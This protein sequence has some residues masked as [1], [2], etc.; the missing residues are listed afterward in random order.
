MVDYSNKCRVPLIVK[1]TFHFPYHSPT[2]VT[3]TMP[4]IFSFLRDILD[5]SRKILLLSD[6]HGY[7]LTGFDSSMTPRHHL[8]LPEVCA[9]AQYL[10]DVGLR[11]SLARQ[12]S[13]TYMD[14]VDRYRKACESHFER[15]TR[16]G[17]LTEYYREVFIVLFKRTTQ[18]WGSQIVSIVRMRICQAGTPLATIGPER[19][20]V[21]A[22]VNVISK[23]LTMLCL[24]SL[25]YA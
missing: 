19:L 10:I 18:A 1:Q 14:S 15:A 9:P 23:L 5:D 7:T 4:G 11:P 13:R 3:S 17:H 6:S 2:T 22:I 8:Y 25:R 20:D 16:G 24:L 12:L 21:S